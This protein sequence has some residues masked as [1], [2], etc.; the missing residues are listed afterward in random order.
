M[1]AGT[2]GQIAAGFTTL[3]SGKRATPDDVR[4]L[5]GRRREEIRQGVEAHAGGGHDKAIRES[6]LAER[7]EL[8]ALESTL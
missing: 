3:P 8:D 1:N 6:L 7:P 5:I 2:I 4:E